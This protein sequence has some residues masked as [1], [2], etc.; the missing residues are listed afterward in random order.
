MVNVTVCVRFRPL[1]L[2]EKRLHGDSICIQALNTQ[3]FTFKD[4]KEEDITFCFDRVFYQDSEQVDVYDFL[5]MPI[6]E[7]AVNA[8]NGTIIAY[9]QTGAGKTYSM[10]G[11]GVLDGD[12]NKKGLL[13]RIV[14]GI[15][16]F[17]QSLV[18]MTKWTVK[19]SMVEIYMDKI[20]DLFDLSKDNIQIKENKCQGIFLLG[21]TE[22]PITNSTEALQCLCHGIANRAVGETQ[23][24]LASSRSHC[25]YIFSVQQESRTNGRL[26]TGKIVLVDLAGSEKADRTGAGGIVLE[27]AKS[28]NKSLSALG[29]VINALTAGKVNHIPYRDSKLTR[30]LQDA[31]GGNSRTA[32]LCCCSPSPSN[33]SESLSTLR[34]GARAKLL[35]SSPRANMS[36]AKD[37]MEQIIDCE[38]LDYKSERLLEKLRQNLN[39]EDVDMLDELLT[40]EGIFFDPQSTEEIES[41]IEDVTIRTISALHQAVEDLKDRNDMLMM[42]NHTL[43][44]DLTAARLALNNA[45]TVPNASLFGKARELLISYLPS[46]NFPLRRYS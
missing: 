7:G 29:N 42:E 46:F 25:V 28:I 11:L 38:S 13:P 36:D 10:E 1:S 39:E 3:S 2:S 12:R 26:K 14:D 27:E 19:L 5:A 40:L 17:L 41:A 31:L 30:I 8:I 22:I 15:F 24:N 33:V 34:F 35:K 43:K 6:I 32:L 18:E 45:K 37:N 44:A 9:G 16:E 23:M 4:E 20:R 21:A